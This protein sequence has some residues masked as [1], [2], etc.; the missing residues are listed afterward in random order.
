ML[1]VFWGGHWETEGFEE[2]A[3]CLMYVF[4]GHGLFLRDKLL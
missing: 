2:V 3:D 1:F 4:V